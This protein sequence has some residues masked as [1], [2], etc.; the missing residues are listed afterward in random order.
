MAREIVST[1]DTNSG[2]PRIDGTR[3]TCANVSQGV[4]YQGGISAYL[5]TYTYLDASDIEA[6]LRYCAGRQCVAN[7]VHNSCEQC[8]LDTEP[9]DFPDDEQDDIWELSAEMLGQH[10][11][12]S[13]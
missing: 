4:R 6:A 2:C 11:P 8:T 12:P 10:F 3:L 5:A 9:P 13:A 7:D 1:P